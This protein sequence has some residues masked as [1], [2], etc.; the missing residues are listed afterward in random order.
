METLLKR[1]EYKIFDKEIENIELRE[2]YL[3][4]YCKYDKDVT[5]LEHNDELK[6]NIL[7]IIKD[8]KCNIIIASNEI[9]TILENFDNFYIISEDDVY[10]YRRYKADIPK[11][12]EPIFLIKEN[13]NNIGLVIKSDFIKFNPNTIILTNSTGSHIKSLIVSNLPKID[14]IEYFKN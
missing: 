3:W 5:Q 2:K 7:K 9:C 1:L 12:F 10:N 13:S 6:N 14:L 11:N 4:D 8:D